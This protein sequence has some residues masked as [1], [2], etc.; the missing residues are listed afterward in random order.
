MSFTPPEFHLEHLLRRCFSVAELRSLLTYL[1]DQGDLKDHLPVLEGITPAMYARQAV[2]ALV[3]RSLVGRPLFNEIAAQRSAL[4]A[5]IWAVAALYGF[6]NPLAGSLSPLPEEYSQYADADAHAELRTFVGR[7]EQLEQLREVLLPRSGPVRAAVV[8]NLRGMAGVGKTFLVERFFMEHRE[9]LPGGHLKITLGIHDAPTG[10]G[11]L[12][13]LAE[14]LGVQL[15]G[16]GRLEDRVRAASLAFRAL[17]HLDNVDS[18]AQARGAAELVARLPGVFLVVTGRFVFDERVTG[19]RLVPVDP[20]NEADALAQ[21]RLELTD[22]NNARIGDDDRRALV[23]ALHGLPLAIRLAASYLN[24]GYRVEDFLSELKSAGLSLPHLTANTSAHLDRT[25]WALIATFDISLTA[26]RAMLG[27][28]AEE[29]MRGVAA[30]GVAPLAGIGRD[31]LNTIVGDEPV[32]VIR[33]VSRAVKLSIVR[34]EAVR[35]RWRVHKLLSERLRLLD[36]EETPRALGRLDGWMIRRLL[37]VPEETLRARWGELQEEHEG[38]GEWVTGLEGERAWEG[39][40]MG[41]DYAKVSGPYAAWLR[42]IARGLLHKT[43]D[44]MAWSRLLWHQGNIALRAGEWDL[45]LHAAETQG[46]HAASQGWDWDVA[47]AAGLRAD[48][49]QARGQ[50]DEALRIRREEVLPIY[51]QLSD[52]REKAITFGKIADVLYTQ[53]HLDE[54]L[55]L[56]RNEELPVFERLGD[57]REKAVTMDKIADLLQERGQFDEALRIRREEVLPVVERHGDVHGKAVTMG[58]IADVLQQRGQLDEA[59]HLRREEELPVYQRLG[60]VRSKAVTMGKIAYI[61]FARGLLDEA[62]RIRREEEL[63]VYQRLGDV[64]SKAISMGDIADVLQARGQIDEALRIR[65]EEVLPVH[66]QLGDVHQKAVIMGRIADALQARG[67]LDEALRIRREEV[68]PIFERLGSR[69]DLCA[70]R[71]TFAALLLKR[72]HPADVAEA[73]ALLLAAE[74]AAVEMNLPNALAA[75]RSWFP[76]AGIPT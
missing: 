39:C 16:E 51:E 74:S 54:A 6:D 44:E 69:C 68:L 65:Q 43:T 61:L 3:A 58:K 62:L 36:P 56:R 38:V 23:T 63:P 67:Q 76:D 24:A 31:L 2:R 9:H 7:V 30:L 40:F 12:R 21:L 59:L 42:A 75:I 26:L 4:S 29:G 32:R 28:E 70:G 48:V 25:Q 19:W 37:I 55:R 15:T 45:A 73:R 5:E 35:E 27:A 41:Y 34:F 13:D 46:A 49:L 14:R 50:F 11:L 72:G 47:L 20:F 22:D 8:C 10:D 57:V 18:Q 33:W 52:E 71:T 1:P 53:G 64:R 17:L 66:E 60:D